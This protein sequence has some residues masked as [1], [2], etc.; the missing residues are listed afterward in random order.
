MTIVAVCIFLLTL[1][2]VRHLAAAG[3]KHWMVG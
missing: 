3:I 2:N 1:P